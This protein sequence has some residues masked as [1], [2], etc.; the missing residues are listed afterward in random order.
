MSYDGGLSTV[1]GVTADGDDRFVA[2][3]R[4]STPERSFGGAVVAQALLAGA[5][6]VQAERPVH[7]LH[8]YFL[9]AG[10]ASSPTHFDVQRVRDG[11]SYSTRRVTAEQD[12]RAILDVSAS[13]HVRETGFTHQIPRLDAPTPESLAT[14][15][16]VAVLTEG[17]VR[18][19]FD[20]FTRRHP[21]DVRFD[22]ELPRVAAGRGEAA[23]PRQRFW[24]RALETLPDE[25]AVHT[26]AL[27]YASDM[28]LLS[29]SLAPHARMVGG[30]GL[31]AASLDHAVWFHEPAR[32]DDW[33]CYEQ[34]SSW[35]GHG[36]AL[37][38]GRVF[39]RTGRLVMTVAQEGMVRALGPR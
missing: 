35:A 17:P 7:S 33:L 25:P 5:A 36:R 6:T 21:F 38:H 8:A 1:L 20:G 13:F 4:R 16:E 15:A 11:G 2:G 37:M 26:A 31:A 23:E 32:V 12:G 30:P 27:A 18:E 10:E 34:A 29:A 9:R 24:F 3:A 19:W 28:L 14:V 39:D 22:G